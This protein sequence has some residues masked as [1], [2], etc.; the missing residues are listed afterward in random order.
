M[1]ILKLLALGLAI[2]AVTFESSASSHRAID[3]SQLPAPYKMILKSGGFADSSSQAYKEKQKIKREECKIREARSDAI[4][5]VEKRLQ[6]DFQTETFLFPFAQFIGDAQFKKSEDGNFHCEVDD[7]MQLTVLWNNLDT[8]R[9]QLVEVLYPTIMVEEVKAIY[10]NAAR[11]ITLQE[12]KLKTIEIF[13]N[14]IKRSAELQGTTEDELDQVIRAITGW[15]ENAEYIK[16]PDI[17]YNRI[18]PLQDPVLIEYKDELE[19]PVLILDFLRTA[20]T[21]Q[22]G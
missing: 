2:T 12:V 10:L 11:P 6:E 9:E 16:N 21:T 5:D 17:E 19:I 18:D 4:N 20:S 8:L 22:E 15:I 1:E 14:E 13:K 3:M 7:S